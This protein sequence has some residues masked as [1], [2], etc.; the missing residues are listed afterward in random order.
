M[1]RIKSGFSLEKMR[2]VLKSCREN[3]EIQSRKMRDAIAIA[4]FFRERDFAEKN[5]ARSR[6]D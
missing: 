1:C 2:F 4:N 3:I 6:R 5:T